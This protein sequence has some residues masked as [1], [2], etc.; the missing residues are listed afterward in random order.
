M[1][2]QGE[3]S[4]LAIDL[5]DYKIFH[6]LAELAERASVGSMTFCLGRRLFHWRLELSGKKEEIKALDGLR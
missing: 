6:L 1:I 5:S 2:W 3:A 4:F